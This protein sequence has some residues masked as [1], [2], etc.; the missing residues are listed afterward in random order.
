MVLWML[1]AASAA[2]AQVIEG[3]VTSGGEPVPGASVQVHG[4]TQGAAAGDD[5]TYRITDLAPGTYELVASAVGFSK[6]ERSVTVEEGETLRVDFTLEETVLQGEELV[7]TGTLEE[8]RVKDSPVKVTVVSS[9]HLQ[10]R[11]SSNLMDAIGTING[12]SQQLNC[13]VCYTNAIRIN[14]MEGEHTAVLVDGM[15]LLGALASVYGL[16]GINPTLIDRVEVVKG[17]K[18]TIY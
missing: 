8:T 5:G 16:N 15:P 1:I 2:R 18:S 3:T 14:G 9:R 7:V 17:P 10:K 6:A 13:G 4:T 12:L 11:A